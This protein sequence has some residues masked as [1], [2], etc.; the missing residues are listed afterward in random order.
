MTMIAGK[1]QVRLRALEPEDL[2]ILYRYEN[3]SSLWEVGTTIAPFS[4]KQLYDYIAGYSNDIYAERQ[5]RLMVDDA[6]TGETVGTVDITDFSPADMRAQA[7][8]L[9][10]TGH[11][12]RGYGTAALAAVCGYCRSTLQLHQLYAHVP[13]DNAA[14]LALFRQ[15]GFRTSGRLRSWLRR[16]GSYR[17]VI[18]LQLLFG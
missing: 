14:S 13:A 10:G 4:R 12:R 1:P 8:I 9:I 3:D 11:Q 18:V 6:A 2:D 5:L 7:G 16:G 17:D 15:C